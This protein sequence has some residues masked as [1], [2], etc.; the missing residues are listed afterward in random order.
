MDAVNLCCAR[1]CSAL[2]FDL[3]CFFPFSGL[4]RRSDSSLSQSVQYPSVGTHVAGRCGRAIPARW[5][6]LPGSIGS[7]FDRR[8]AGVGRGNTV[9]ATARQQQ[10]T[11]HSSECAHDGQCV[12]LLSLQRLRAC[13]LRSLLDR[14]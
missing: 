14:C 10:A 12:P 4:S 3:R 9:M 8:A 13:T 7:A 6:R 1:D 11:T 5:D 2:A